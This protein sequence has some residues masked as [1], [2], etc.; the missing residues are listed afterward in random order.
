[1]IEDVKV[2]FCSVIHF[3]HPLNKKLKLVHRIVVLPDYQGIGLSKF[4]LNSIGDIYKRDGFDLRLKTSS[5]AMKE[6]LRH[7]I[8]WKPV[9][10]EIMTGNKGHNTNMKWLNKT[11]S[12]KRVTFSFK[13]IGKK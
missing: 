11:R 12:G 3:P 13:Y 5:V 9:G 2:G 8:E 1:M 10:M 6:A 7:N 4:I